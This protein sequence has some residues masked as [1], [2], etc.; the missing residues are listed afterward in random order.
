MG[1]GGEGGGDIT[2]HRAKSLPFQQKNEGG[3]EVGKEDG[4]S[5]RG[6]VD[7]TGARDTVVT[8]SKDEHGCRRELIAGE[9]GWRHEGEELR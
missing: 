5:W 8:P 9:G 4:G 2:A 1:V 7:S 3:V 6:R